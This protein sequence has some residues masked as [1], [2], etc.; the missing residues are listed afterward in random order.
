[1]YLGTDASVLVNVMVG[2]C[3]FL[4]SFFNSSAKSEYWRMEIGGLG[5]HEGMNFSCSH[6]A[7]E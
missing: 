3:L 1:M 7:K 2:I 5:K 4:L 6:P